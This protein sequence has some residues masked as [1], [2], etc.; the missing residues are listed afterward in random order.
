MPKNTPAVQR[1]RDCLGEGRIILY[2]N[3]EDGPITID[4]YV[5]HPCWGTGYVEEPR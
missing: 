5:C 4:E 2:R 3:V 1:C